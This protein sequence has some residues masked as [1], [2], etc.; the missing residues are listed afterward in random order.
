MPEPDELRR[1]AKLA[2]PTP[3]LAP[4]VSPTTPCKTVIL[5]HSLPDGSSHFDW[6]LAVEPR[7]V[8]PLVTF[9]ME[10]RVDV[11]TFDDNCAPLAAVSIGHHRPAYLN[12]EGPVSGDRGEVSRM[13]SGVIESWVFRNER[14]WRM[15]VQW[16]D[17]ARRDARQFLVLRA[18]ESGM[19]H[20]EVI[21]T[22]SEP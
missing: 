18:Q 21:A 12:Y 7:G 9:R 22:D 4:E 5:R 10:Q 3:L 1:R 15:A 16:V 20:W 11:L 13:A 17:A 19:M 6:L 14:H 8:R 2:Q